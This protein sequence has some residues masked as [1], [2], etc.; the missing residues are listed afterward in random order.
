[1]LASNHNKFSN[2]DLCCGQARIRRVCEG[3]NPSPEMF[4]KNC[5]IYT[6]VNHK[7]VINIFL[8]NFFIFFNFRCCATMRNGERPV[9]QSLS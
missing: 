9:V 7:S 5:Q 1:M 3:G 4:S 8:E 6:K 2:Y